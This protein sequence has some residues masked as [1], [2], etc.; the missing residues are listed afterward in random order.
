MSN[1]A[2]GTPEAEIVEALSLDVS[3]DTSSEKLRTENF[4]EEVLATLKGLREDFA[5]REVSSVQVMAGDG[6]LAAFNSAGEM[7]I[8]SGD[9]DEVS[10]NEL[11]EINTAY[12][13][14]KPDGAKQFLLTGFLVYG[15]KQVNSST[16][17]TVVIYEASQPD[18]I[19]ED[20][21]LFQFEVGQNQSIPFP[22]IRILGTKGAYVNAKTS[23]DDIHMTI[24]GHYI[25]LNGG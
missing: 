8:A 7:L 11:A 6:K 18:S 13:F 22:N 23:D 9:Y 16:N 2:V 24:V 3:V 15:D 17:A 10:F 19:A 1:N 25:D 5:E 21:V 14:F 20:R 4:Q 12:N